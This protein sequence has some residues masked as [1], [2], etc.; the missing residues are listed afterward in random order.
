ME[1][2]FW[3]IILTISMTTIAMKAQQHYVNSFSAPTGIIVHGINPK[4][5][6]TTQ[7]SRLITP[8][9]SPS[10]PSS[11]HSYHSNLYTTPTSSNPSTSFP[12][13]AP[14][15]ILT[16]CSSTGVTISTLKR[17][18][19]SLLYV[20]NAKGDV[21]TII[22]L[23]KDE[24]F[25]DISTDGT[26][27][28][29]CWLDGDDLY[30]TV[31]SKDKDIKQ[32]CKFTVE[33]KKK[34][35][36]EQKKIG[37]I[38]TLGEGLTTPLGELL[39][40]V[41]P[42][43]TVVKCNISHLSPSPPS[44]TPILPQ[45]TSNTHETVVQPTVIN[46]RIAVTAYDVEPR[47]MGGIYCYQR[48][49]N[50]R[51]ADEGMEK[52]MPELGYSRH[53][54]SVSGKVVVFGREEIFQTHVG[55][56]NIY[57]DGVKVQWDKSIFT[58]DDS[59]NNVIKNAVEGGFYLNVLTGSRVAVV[60]VD[61]V[62]RVIEEV[63]IGEEWGSGVLH[64]A[65]KGMVAIRVSSPVD[66]GGIR[67][68]DHSKKEFVG[69]IKRVT[70]VA[71]VEG[72]VVEEMEGVKWEY[73]NAGFEGK[74]NAD[75]PDC[76]VLLPPSYT[77]D[78]NTPLIV[79]PHGG[80]HSMTHAG[81]IPS[82]HML[83]SMGYAVLHV[84]YRGSVGFG[85]AYLDSLPGK[86]GTVDVADVREATKVAVEKYNLNDERVG[87]A[88]GSHG[89]FLSGHM[90]G[91]FPDVYKVAV[92]RN[93]VTNIATMTTATD[94]RDWCDVEALGTYDFSNFRAASKEELGKMWDASPCRYAENVKAK[95]LV[96]VGL[97]DLRVPP[98]QGLEFYYELKSRGLQCKLLR[99][100]ED[101]HP[102]SKVD[103][104]ADHWVNI[105]EFFQEYL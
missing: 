37:G 17:D 62:K 82:Y 28:G 97:K 77:S 100:E 55:E 63:E 24:G 38:W 89:G 73:M 45:S 60:F 10:T 102:L 5:L 85:G 75:A 49:V 72:Y 95:V 41:D 68:Y 84:N 79:V 39:T 94:I 65:E 92:M 34:E 11:S 31:E 56:I 88:G 76:I 40:N 90:V 44:F 18:K 54:I 15:T 104:E 52:I 14:P 3:L 98:S 26:R 48:P 99:Y 7:K 12:I 69:G 86:V 29:G 91:Q 35:G 13:T 53:P 21:P 67:I 70:K 57:V 6:I 25:G 30:L 20:Q 66:P 58:I 47:R 105:A 101:T 87:I 33:K 50:A 27:Y 81:Y 46:G 80:P 8:S 71:P 42:R 32:Q 16:R 74:E 22:P 83:A 78:S 103:T 64:G 19:T 36:E 43:L 93:P 4:I 96:A 2:L 59:P 23:P 9:S 51:W 1:T 61:V